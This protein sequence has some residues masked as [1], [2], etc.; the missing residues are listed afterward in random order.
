[1][2]FSLLIFPVSMAVTL[3]AALPAADVLLPRKQFPLYKNRI[4]GVNSKL[5]LL[6]AY[7]YVF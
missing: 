7:V 1:M 4:A 2:N 6:Y 3:D 5:A